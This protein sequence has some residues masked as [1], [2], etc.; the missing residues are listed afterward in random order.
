MTNAR[1]KFIAIVEMF[2][3]TSCDIGAVASSGSLG[4]AL[5]SAGLRLGNLD[6]GVG[7]E[8]ATGT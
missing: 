6:G 4:R 1:M 3:R 2:W 7:S 8:E 5:E